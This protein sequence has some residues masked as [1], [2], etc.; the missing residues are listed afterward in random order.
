MQS[1]FRVALIAITAGLCSLNVAHAD[2]ARQIIKDVISFMQ[3]PMWVGLLA[4]SWSRSND[5]TRGPKHLS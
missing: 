1:I 3:T 2:S 5:S 4:R